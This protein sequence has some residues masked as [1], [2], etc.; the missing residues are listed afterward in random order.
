MRYLEYKLQ[1]YHGSMDEHL[2]KIVLELHK[3]LSKTKDKISNRNLHLEADTLED[4]AGILVDFAA[5]IHA[6]IG[7]WNCFE[8]YNIEFFGTPLP[9]TLEH[10]GTTGNMKQKQESEWLSFM[11]HRLRFMAGT[12]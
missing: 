9:L 2:P 3:L 12:R 4:I 7:I 11:L 5:D 6:D 8:R 1:G 10:T